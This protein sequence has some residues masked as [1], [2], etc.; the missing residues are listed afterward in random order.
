MCGIALRRIEAAL[1]EQGDG[2]VD[3][4]TLYPQVLGQIKEDIPYIREVF[5]ALEGFICHKEGQESEKCQEFKG[6][7]KMYDYL[8][9]AAVSEDA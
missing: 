8:N 3:V 9:L 1:G 4:D 5:S 7:H 6:I 2:A